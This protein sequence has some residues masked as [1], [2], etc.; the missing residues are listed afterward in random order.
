MHAVVTTAN[1]D[2]VTDERTKNLRENI[3]PMVKG[4]PGFIA[5]YWLAPVDGKGMSVVVFED[6]ASAKAAA[7]APGQDMGNGVTIASV[8]FRPVLANG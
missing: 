7:P 3:V 4:A 5:G 6:E 8:E 1:V 2:A